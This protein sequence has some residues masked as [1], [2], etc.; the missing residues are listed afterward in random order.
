MTRRLEGIVYLKWRTRRNRAN[1]LSALLGAELIA[2]PWSTRRNKWNLPFRLPPQIARTLR[3]LLR[4]RPRIVICENTHPYGTLSG[5]IYC[6]LTGAHY[7]L[8]CHNST[9]QDPLWN[10]RVMLKLMRWLMSNAAAVI[11]HNDSIR[12]YAIETLKMR[13]NFRVVRSPIPD[14]DVPAP[15]D[16]ASPSVLA[17]CSYSKFEP[18]RPILN[19]ARLTPEVYYYLTGDQTRAKPEVIGLAG[20]NVTFTGYVPNERFD[21]L[22]G[23]AD[24]VMCLDRRDNLLQLAQHQAIGAHRPIVTTDIP[25]ARGYLTQG[26]VFVQ[27]TPESIA[28]GVREAIHRRDELREQI[29]ALKPIRQREQAEQVASLLAELARR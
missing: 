2:M 15:A 12:R 20:P 21:Q 9:F 8:D 18:V 14:Y 26:A 3:V 27:N 24:V 6:R 16:L 25:T 17:I 5:M 22:L 1:A 13:G 11:V 19:A 28:A 10:R 7:A 4:R 23:G 29:R